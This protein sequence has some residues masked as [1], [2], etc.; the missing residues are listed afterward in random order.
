VLGYDELRRGLLRGLRNG[1]WRRL[2]EIERSLYIAA[3]CYTRKKCI[4]RE[5]LVEKLRSL[6]NRLLE[7]PSL[8]IFKKG[9]AKSLDLLAAALPEWIPHMKKWLK[10]P[11]YVFWLGSIG[12]MIDA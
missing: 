6:L 10:D 12:K 3:L 2:S 1:N 9:L 5:R 8:R 4:V 11:D 7:T